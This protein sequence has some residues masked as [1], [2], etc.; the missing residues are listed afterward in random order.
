M[1][2]PNPNDKFQSTS[3]FYLSISDLM[4]SVLVIFIVIFIAQVLT[5]NYEK[6]EISSERDD[7]KEIIGGFE[8]TRQDIISLITEKIDVEID[9]VTGDIRMN[10]EIMFETNSDQLKPEGKLFLKKF[11]P[12]YMGVLLGN[13][14]IK[15]NISQIIIEGHTDKEGTY[16][17]NL[18]LSQ[19]RAIAVV[20]FIYSSEMPN[21]PGKKDL[22]HFI[23]ANGRSFIDFL[24]KDNQIRHAASRRVEFKFKLKEDE[25]IQRLKDKIDKKYNKE[26]SNGT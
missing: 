3:D 23:T 17:H 1:T 24:G 20:N 19:N 21:F 12:I 4:A 8:S 22:M 5:L 6:G 25:T 14:N 18:K 7:Y 2:Q 9:N 10:S 15:N 16:L 26:L 11:I 13:E